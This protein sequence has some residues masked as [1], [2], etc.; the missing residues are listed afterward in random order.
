MADSNN[1]NSRNLYSPF[2]NPSL[3]SFNL[4]VVNLPCC[5]CDPNFNL[6]SENDQ[7]YKLMDDESRENF[8]WYIGNNTG[9]IYSSY[10][11]VKTIERNFS[12]PISNG[13]G[14]HQKS[15]VGW[16]QKYSTERNFVQVTPSSHF[17]VERES[18]EAHHCVINLHTY[19]D[20]FPSIEYP[21]GANPNRKW[22][23][24]AIFEACDG[25]ESYDLASLLAELF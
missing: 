22:R 18:A 20:G 7:N 21:I 19:F 10:R 2:I 8:N 1:V 13:R 5:I 9:N 16:N 4:Y 17:C 11:T 6:M 24:G 23:W 15:Y 14:E 25:L 3:A 12:N